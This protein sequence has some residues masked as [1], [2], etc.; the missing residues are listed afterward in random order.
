MKIYPSQHRI[1]QVAGSNIDRDITVPLAYVNNENT[2]YKISR[3]VNDA[4]SVTT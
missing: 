3:K 1:K 4:F 2:T